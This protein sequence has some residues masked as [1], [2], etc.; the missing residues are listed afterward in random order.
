MNV[1]QALKEKSLTTLQ[2]YFASAIQ[3]QTL[4]NMHSRLKPGQLEVFKLR[5]ANQLTPDALHAFFESFEYE[6][7]MKKLNLEECVQLSGVT[8]RELIPLRF[9]NLTTLSLQ[10]CNNHVDSDA[11]KEVCIHCLHLRKLKLAGCKYL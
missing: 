8:V 7:N 1:I 11:I 6:P 4:L 5:K 2:I 3:D 9:P 10:W